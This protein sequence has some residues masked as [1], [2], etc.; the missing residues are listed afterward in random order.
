MRPLDS[1]EGRSS[2]KRLLASAPPGEVRREIATLGA[3]A[4]GA[5]EAAA[6]AYAE[7]A[8]ALREGALD[9]ALEALDRAARAFLAAGEIE[10]S[11]LSRCEAWI[12]RVRRGPRAACVEAR[13]ALDTLASATAS[14]RVRVVALHYRGAAERAAGDA[15]GAERSLLDALAGAEPFL[16]E[17]AQIL[18]SLGTLRVAQG[19]LGAAEALL[20]HAAELQRRLGDVTG[21]A[22][23][24]GQLGAAALARGA[25]ADARRHLQRQEWLASRVGDAFGQARALGM[26]AEVALDAGRA[27]EA[28]DLAD[29]A[30]SVAESVDPPLALWI[31]YATR[32]RARA[33]LDLG[34]REGARE[35]IDRAASAFAGRAHPL[36]TALVEADRARLGAGEGAP[37]AWFGPAWSLGSLGLASR[38]ARVLADRR[39]LGVAG[40][41][42]GLALAAVAQASPH[43]AAAEE[44]ALAHADPAALVTIAARRTA[45]QRNLGRLAALA[46]APRGLAVAALAARAIGQDR[47]ALP[48][49]RAAA[50][51]V[52]EMPGA[53]L[54]VWPASASVEEIARDLSAARAALG[55]DL[56]AWVIAAEE[57]RVIAPPFLGDVG[58]TVEGIDGAALLARAFG[59]GPGVIAGEAA[60]T[61]EARGILA[62]AGLAPA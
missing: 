42:E 22:I 60:W 25:H 10:A 12:A 26:L 38:V 18:C 37:A 55:E 3:S 24:H 5:R 16:D 2:I 47:R 62:M 34:D 21:E 29:R 58:A 23:A 6:I 51:A 15:A 48:P 13:E 57:A 46:I 20:E 49:D 39:A 45:A 61:P 31:G 4:G 50:A 28:R 52:V 11:E 43:L 36:G 40:E 32:A 19:A 41:D 44:V 56:R 27:M 54:W 14:A 59:L 8:L 30:V 9:E 7:G 33:L 1:I 53:A 35:A 17:R